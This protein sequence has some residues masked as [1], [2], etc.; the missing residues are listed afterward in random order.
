MQYSVIV[1]LGRDRILLIIFLFSTDKPW[2]TPKQGFPFYGM[3]RY[4][5]HCLVARSLVAS[6][7]C[8]GCILTPQCG[9]ELEI[10]FIVDRLVFWQT[11]CRCPLLCS[12]SFMAIDM[13][14]TNGDF[15]LCLNSWPRAVFLVRGYG[16]CYC[17]FVGAH[18]RD[19]A[20]GG[21]PDRDICGCKKESFSFTYPNHGFLPCLLPRLSGICYFYKKWR[22][23][24]L[25]LGY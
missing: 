14:E 19:C 8:H 16:Y 11:A 2:L 13:W 10:A 9:K 12:E 21:V 7:L 22:L 18:A 24:V 1:P 4:F 3:D 17:L 6:F 5:R 15:F 23:E 25:G 20:F